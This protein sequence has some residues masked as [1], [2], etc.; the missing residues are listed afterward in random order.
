[1]PSAPGEVIR[2]TMD[3][4]KDLK[5]RIKTLPSVYELVDGKVSVKLL[6]DIRSNLLGR[7]PVDLDW[8][9]DRRL[10]RRTNCTVTG[11]GGSANSEICR[12]ITSSSRR[13]L[14]SWATGEQ[15]LRDRAGARPEASRA[16]RLQ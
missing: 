6:R 11:A 16:A 4:C 2:A 14:S 3:A 7:E 9:S 10:S 8:G 12:Q 15:H 13:A 1:M 5:V